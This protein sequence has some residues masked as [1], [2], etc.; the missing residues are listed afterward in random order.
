MNTKAATRKFHFVLDLET[1][2]DKGTMS[3]TGSCLNILI[4]PAFT[5]VLEASE[6]R[7]YFPL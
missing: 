4:W 2:V 1:P 6:S 5:F 3:S 7:C